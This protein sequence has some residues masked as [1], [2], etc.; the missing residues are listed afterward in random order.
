[1]FDFVVMHYEP[2]ILVDAWLIVKV[3]GSSE[4]F[5]FDL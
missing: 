1:M 4:S 2:Q 5:D 3:F